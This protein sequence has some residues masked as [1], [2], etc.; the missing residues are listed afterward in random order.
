[1]SSDNNLL[2]HTP[3]VLLYVYRITYLFVMILLQPFSI[4]PFLLTTDQKD[5]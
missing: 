2:F 4:E 3:D 5:Y 1:M